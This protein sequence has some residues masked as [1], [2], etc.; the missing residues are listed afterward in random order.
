[1]STERL[2][3]VF[4]S[5]KNQIR[6]WI[7]SG[8]NLRFP[9]T[10]FADGSTI[11]SY[12]RSQQISKSLI[13]QVTLSPPYLAR[14]HKSLTHRRSSIMANLSYRNCGLLAHLHDNCH[15]SSSKLSLLLFR[16]TNQIKSTRIDE[17]LLNEHESSTFSQIVR[18]WRHSQTR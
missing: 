5:N 17:Y 10:T 6:Q 11:A 4:Y 16:E 7:L 3:R 8:T 13:L 2:F 14:F 12:T 15:R 18:R 9:Q 1:M